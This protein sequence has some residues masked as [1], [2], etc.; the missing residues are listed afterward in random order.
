MANKTVV[1]AEPNKQELFITREF[2]L[3]RKSVF[4]AHVDPELYRQWVFPKEFAPRVEVFDM[5]DGGSYKHSHERNGERFAIFGINHEVQAPERIISTFEFDGL[6]ER[7]HVIMR[8]TTFEELPGG[9]TRLVQQS[10]FLSVAERDGM[11][12][13]GTMERYINEG[14]DRLETLLADGSATHQAA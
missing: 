12:Q 5:F 3:P 13:G 2:D 9:R 6:P 10:V 14:F 7:G 11:M 8:K 1:T 4:N